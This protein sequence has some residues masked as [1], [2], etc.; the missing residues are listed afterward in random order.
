MSESVTAIDIN[1]SNGGGGHSAN[2]TSVKNAKNPDGTD[3]LGRVEGNFGRRSDFSDQR[4]DNLLKNFILVERTTTKGPSVETV[5]RKYTDRTSLALNSYLVLVRGMNATPREKINEMTDGGAPMLIDMPYF[6][7]VINSPDMTN[8]PFEV[9]PPL[10]HKAAIIAGRIYNYESAA[11]PRGIKISLVYNNRELQDGT[12]ETPDLS[13]NDEWVN[14]SY[15][16]SKDGEPF[17]TGPDLSQYDLKFGYTLKDFLAI[18]EIAGITATGLPNPEDI[19]TLFTTSG[20]LGSVVSSVASYFGLYWWVDPKTGNI[21]FISS[22]AARQLRILNPT[23]A[24]NADES[25]VTASFT[26]SELANSVV[27][28]Y[29]GSEEKKDDKAPKDDDRPRP[30]FF[31]RVQLEDFIPENPWFKVEGRAADSPILL[32]REKLGT[33]FTLFNQGCS[34]DQFNKLCF[35]SMFMDFGKDGNGDQIPFLQYAPLYLEKPAAL[36]IFDYLAFGQAG[37]IYTAK[38]PLDVLQPVDKIKGAAEAKASAKLCELEVPFE[39]QDQNKEWN[40]IEHK[41]QYYRLDGMHSDEAR[42]AGVRKAKDIKKMKD[43]ENLYD[44][45]KAYF[46]VAGGIFVSN[47]YSEY[48]SKRM[49]WNNTNN[50]TVLGPYR[51]DT[52]IRRVDELSMLNDIFNKLK[53]T[54]YERDANTGKPKLDEFGSKIPR[55]MR[56]EDLAETTN[57]EAMTI[58]RHVEGGPPVNKFHFVAIRQFPKLEKDNGKGLDE[59]DDFEWLDREIEFFEPRNR[60]RQRYIGGPTL[61]TVVNPHFVDKT[62]A[63]IISSINKYDAAMA[64]TS[65]RRLKLT[66]TRSKTEVN[67]IGEAGEV[68]A[69]NALSQ[70]SDSAQKISDLFDRYDSKSFVIASPDHKLTRPVSLVTTNGSTTEIAA[71]A[72]ARGEYGNVENPLN[73]SSRTLYGLHIPE[74]FKATTSSLSFSMNNNGITTTIGESTLNLI[75][76]DQDYLMS[77]GMEAIRKDI[78]SRKFNA[79]QRN[80]FGL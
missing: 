49:S 69:D 45:M 62:K 14:D 13:L 33:F 18:L 65:K 42:V 50:I 46:E 54:G 48:K 64:N 80:Y 68:A 15:K 31:R 66:Y 47:S 63:L 24:A 27:N 17:G 70:S 26:E 7:E 39:L 11:D 16:G 79:A 71:M 29:S 28:V 61:N 57:G 19:Q 5:S 73:T 3:S 6:S 9:L 10:R 60:P 58:P 21:R 51:Y 37:G 2:I 8:Y 32:S 1:F 30:C 72:A 52:E 43:P 20:S 12:N 55:A 25:V 74:E 36:N 34:Q 53:M 75:P 41:F 38:D 4:I 56:I 77:Q 59:W 40:R 23:D 44:Y 78:S 22:D 35:L 67:K 76:P